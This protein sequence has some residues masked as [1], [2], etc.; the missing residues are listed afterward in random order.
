MQFLKSILEKKYR[1]CCRS[2]ASLNPTCSICSYYV[3]VFF[4]CF[5]LS[6]FVFVLCFVFS[7]LL[8]IVIV[9]FSFFFRNIKK[10][11]TKTYVNFHLINWW[12]HFFNSSDQSNSLFSNWNVY[13]IFCFPTAN[14][15]PLSRGHPYSP[16]VNYCIL[17]ISTRRPSRN[18]VES[19]MPVEC[20]VGFEAETFQLDYYVL[21]TP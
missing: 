7:L 14:F 19:L 10:Y 6:S 12:I 3:T 16:D 4:F 17:S 8:I 13:R 2:N 15:R 18:E 5:V 11:V 9:F 1:F 20:L 21:L